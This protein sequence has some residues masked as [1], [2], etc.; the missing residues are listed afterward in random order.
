[1][2]YSRGSLRLR[3]KPVPN[4][5][6]V[7]SSQTEL[8]IHRYICSD[9]FGGAS[10]SSLTDRGLT[11]RTISEGPPTVGNSTELA[12]YLGKLSLDRDHALISG[13]HAGRALARPRESALGAVVDSDAIAKP[14][15]GGG[16]LFG[17]CF[18]RD[19]NL[20]VD[21]HRLG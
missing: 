8:D 6:T 1:I 14:S 20:K 21:D 5:S 4:R 9:W 17:G 13:H 15:C 18:I 19:R 16:Q 3:A 12:A 7:P 2:L 11:C 10:P